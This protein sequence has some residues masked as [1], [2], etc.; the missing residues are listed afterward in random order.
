MI[1][2]FAAITSV[3]IVALAFEI[4]SP[5]HNTPTGVCTYIEG[6]L[7]KEYYCSYPN[8]NLTCGPEQYDAARDLH[9]WDCF[10]K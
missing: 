4:G 6:T 3:S 7:P 2:M 10:A 1:V 9:Y 8:P 5:Q